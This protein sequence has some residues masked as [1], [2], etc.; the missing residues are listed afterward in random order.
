MLKGIQNGA[1][2]H[3][4]DPRRTTSAAWADVWLGL[5]VGAD[6]ALAN[7]MARE[8]FIARGT[9][10]YD[11]YREAVEPYTLE[12]GERVTGLPADVIRSSAHAYAK[13][14]RAMICWTL[15]ITE[16]HNAVDNVLALINLA[17]LTGHVGR[18]G[19]G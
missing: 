2:L 18:Y 15:G 4:V 3:V 10:G 6:V 17:L 8:D 12:F 16:H 13:A 11:A 5:N 7:T 19:C 9:T 1:T 14:D